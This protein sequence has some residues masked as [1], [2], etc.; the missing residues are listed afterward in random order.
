MSERETFSADF[1][2]A[3]DRFCEAA[4]QLGWS[5]E[6]LRH[7]GNGPQGEELTTDVAIFDGGDPT[8]T[9]LITSGVHGV[10]GFFGS[11]VQLALM[12]QWQAS[13]P[14]PVRCV[15]VHAVNPYG[16]AWRRRFDGNNVDLN[17]NFLLPG[18]EYAGASD[19]YADL[20]SFLNPRRP[21][22]SWEP[23][24]VKTAWLI[25]RHGLAELR[26]AI[27]SGQYE[28]PQ[29]VFFG[30]AKPSP[31][32]TL[33]EENLP[34]WLQ[35]SQ[36]VMHLDLHTGL[37]PMG[38][39]KLL[40]DYPLTDQQREKLTRWFGKDSFSE[41]EKSNIAYEV[42]G[43]FG[44]WC[45]GK[46]F[47]PNFLHVCAE[48]GTYGPVTVLQG[49][50]AENQAQHWCEPGDPRIAKTKER[51]TELFCPKDPAWRTKV[52]LRGKELAAQAISGLLET[53]TT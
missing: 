19:A 39:D 31:A 20:D 4:S 50:R 33:L 43:G 34:R 47:A 13:G 46:K 2:L 12:Q 29:G 23:F 40:V 53:S 6:S 52:V 51:L 32:V 1:K 28:F 48:I 9:L 27:A 17:R 44:K 25:A 3:R 26:Q 10:E 49:L 22:S 15:F 8:K 24:L 21:P 41:S 30:G 7:A 37:G 11:A 16:F 38:T 36:D 45:V 42:R 5:L 14:P 35:E 18:E